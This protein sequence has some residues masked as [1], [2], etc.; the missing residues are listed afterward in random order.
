MYRSCG[1][2]EYI[3][4]LIG[5]ESLNKFIEQFVKHDLKILPEYFE[6]VASG[7]KK[8]EL[9]KN[10]RDYKVHDMFVLREWEPDKGYTGRDYIDEIGYILK[11]C[12]QYGLMNGYIIFGW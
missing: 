8:F 5:Q 7:K 4:L 6:A 9:R 10:D 12:P 3:L 2:C 11:D 1:F